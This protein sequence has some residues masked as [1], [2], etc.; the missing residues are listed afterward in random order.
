MNPPPFTPN[1]NLSFVPSTPG[2][3]PGTPTPRGRGAGAPTGAKRGRKPRGA[4]PNSASNTPRVTAQDFKVPANPGGSGVVQAAL[5]WPPASSA[6][7]G[8]SL[9]LPGANAL[10][11]PTSVAAAGGANAAATAAL[12]SRL[13]QLSL[14]ATDFASTPTRPLVPG[15]GLPG[16]G[17]EEDGE[18]DELLPAMADDDYSAQ[19][20]WQSQSKDNL[21]CVVAHCAEC[22]SANSGYLQ[23]PHGQLQR[24]AI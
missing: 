16:Q 17:V 15:G 3:Y 22:D 23:G 8:P 7:A 5:Q 21:K 2:A 24:D 18:E 11:L 20:S 10:Q 4:G 14:P 13:T 19:L 9:A 1:P 6:G 12:Q